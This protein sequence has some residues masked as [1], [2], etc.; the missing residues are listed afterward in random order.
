MNAAAPFAFPFFTHKKSLI[1]SVHAGGRPLLVSPQK[2]HH[3]V[4]LFCGPFTN[5]QATILLVSAVA[6]FLFLFLNRERKAPCESL[7]SYS[8]A[9]LPEKQA[10]FC[11]WNAVA[12]FHFLFRRQKSPI[13]LVYAGAAPSCFTKRGTHFDNVFSVPLTENKAP[14]QQTCHF[15]NPIL[16]H[17]FC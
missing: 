7:L 12:P 3:F 2:P 11:Q 17:P 6:P 14:P 5:K 9:P 1:L 10:P 15:L 8:A 16:W 4:N 13:L